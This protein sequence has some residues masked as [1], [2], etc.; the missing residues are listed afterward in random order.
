MSHRIVST[1]DYRP[2]QLAY[3]AAYDQATGKVALS[4]RDKGLRMDKD[5]IRRHLESSLFLATILDD[6][7]TG[8]FRQILTWARRRTDHLTGY[9]RNLAEFAAGQGAFLSSSEMKGHLA[10]LDFYVA[11]YRRKIRHIPA[12]GFRKGLEAFLNS[13]KAVLPN[14]NV[15]LWDELAD[16]KADGGLLKS[17]IMSQVQP[18]RPAGD[19]FYRKSSANDQHAVSFVQ[20]ANSAPGRIYELGFSYAAYRQYIHPAATKMILLLFGLILFALAGFRL[21]F[22]GTFIYPMQRLVEGVKRVDRGDLNVA[23]PVRAA[24]EIGYLTEAFNRMV[25]SIKQ[26]N[27]ALNDTRL[28]LKNIIDSMPSV[29]IGVDPAGHV[30]HWNQEAER[31]SRIDEDQA[32]GAAIEKLI[33]QFNA[34]LENLHK[35]IRNREPQKIEK[36]AYQMA[37][38]TRYSDIIVYPLIANGVK[39]AVVRIDDITSRVRFEEMMVQS[40]KMASIGGLAAGMAHEINNPL[41][42]ILMAAQNIERRVSPD[43][44]KNREV[45]EETGADMELIADYMEKRGVKKMVAGILEMGQR[46][47]DIVANMLN[48]SRKSEARAS[49]HNV[50]DLIEA[51]IELAANDYNLKKQY[52]FRHIH[53]VRDYEATLPMILCISTEIQQVFLNI[54]KN[55]A[56]AMADKSY[57]NESPQIRIRT[58]REGDMA[59]VEVSDNGPGMPE[60]VRKRIFEPFFTTKEVGTGTGLGLSVSYFIVTENHGGQMAVSARAGKGTKFIIKLPLMD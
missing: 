6:H 58:A 27:K 3:V 37:G 10:K 23:V 30:T 44:K 15:A 7:G 21:F 25:D 52:D 4:Y 2:A 8:R 54:L 19:R 47:S 57:H 5:R 49:T 12:S 42:G 20:H 51:T 18:L 56:Q 60:E 59:R 36:V 16:S 40:E 13:G 50:N 1:E 28:Y 26:S 48:F 53:I 29:L 33:P 17:E 43:L 14:F 11:Y 55:S 32:C 46:A 24:D 31:I 35:A 41:G 9:I 45:A 22:L 34:Y 38:E 39:G